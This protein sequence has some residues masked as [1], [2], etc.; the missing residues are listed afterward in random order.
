MED[1][2]KY[3]SVETIK[4]LKSLSENLQSLETLSGADKPELFR[5]L[6][7][8][9]GSSQTF[10]FASSSRLAHELE[11]FLVAGDEEFSANKEV[12]NLFAKGIRLLIKSLK[13]KDFE[14]PVDFIK[15]IRAFAPDFSAK[16]N[17]LETLLPDIPI[18]ISSQLSSQEKKSA[19]SALNSGKTLY[20]IEINFDSAS[21][22]REFKAFREVLSESGEIIA[23][24]PSRNSIATG[25]IGFQIIFAGFMQT[26][27]IRK[28]IEKNAAELI[29][30][31]SPTVFSND[32]QGVLA[33]A[34]KHG[35]EIAKKLGK[36]IEFAVS[37]ENPKLSIEKL[38][39]IFDVL[40]H[41]TRNAVD[42]AIKNEGKIEINLRAEEKGITLS[43][44][45]DGDGI[46][47]EKV[48]ARAIDKK[49]I[50]AAQSLNEQEILDLIFL[51]ELS[52]ASELTEISGRGIG[53]DSVKNA[54]EKAE[55]KINV[56][57]QS[58]QGTKF[59]VFLPRNEE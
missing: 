44:S 36:R 45:D 22:A 39:L 23:T 56:E 3:F 24:L 4:K 53:L 59:E 50:S 43:I 40:L 16:P 48:K 17:F 55:G 8:V 12:K 32:L 47:L 9:K 52:T 19:A 6:H 33:Q 34:V 51:P 5:T 46:D 29:F 35:Q 27:Q 42:H 2:H 41:L 31:T 54:V 1:L 10:G 37:A 26:A 15:K 30:D 49:L 21:F 13:E 18:E 57:S 58:G 28:T 14:I 20:G 11:N 25:K 7:T 38:K